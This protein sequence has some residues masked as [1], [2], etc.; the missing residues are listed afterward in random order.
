[1]SKLLTVCAL[2]DEFP[3]HRRYE[4]VIFTGVGKVNAAIATMQAVIELQPDLVVNIG[5]CGSNRKDLSGL[6]EV[7][8]FKNKD[9]TFNDETIVFDSTKYNI[10][11]SDSF[12]HKRSGSDL[13]DME[14]FA[15]AKVCKVYGIRFRCF[16]YITDYPESNSLGDWQDNISKG[17]FYYTEVLDSLYENRTN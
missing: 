14:S 9:D 6:I 8:V 15:I 7:G 4:N 2:R 12:Q 3:S 13:V 10:S 16:K 17:D 1:M 11:T 5:T